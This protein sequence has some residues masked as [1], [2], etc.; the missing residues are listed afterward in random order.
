MEQVPLICVI[1]IFQIL[2]VYAFEIANNSR[3]SFWQHGDFYIQ[4]PRTIDF[5]PGGVFYHVKH[6]LN[7]V[8]ADLSNSL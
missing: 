6:D 3:A 4:E 7:I 5:I 2:C 1:L 8:I